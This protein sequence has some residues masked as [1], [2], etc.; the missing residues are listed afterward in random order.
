MCQLTNMA[1]EHA[2]TAWRKSQNLTQD[3]LAGKLGV[4]RWMVNRLEMGERTPSFDLAIR[5]QVL[6]D[7]KVKPADFSRR[8]TAA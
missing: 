3:Q 7:D 6:T 5:I 1:N 2:L 4:T 8:E